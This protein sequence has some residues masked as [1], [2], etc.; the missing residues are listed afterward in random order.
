MTHWCFTHSIPVP[1]HGMEMALVTPT[2]Y[3]YRQLDQGG[4]VLII[5]Y[6]RADSSI[7]HSYLQPLGFATTGIH[8]TAPQ[9]LVSV[10]HRWGERVVLGEGVFMSHLLTCIVS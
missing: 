10:L 5:Y 7:Q 4:S 6:A 1:G 2:N 3:L 9:S 8:G